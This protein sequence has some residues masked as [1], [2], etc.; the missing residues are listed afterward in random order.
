V[1]HNAIIPKAKDCFTFSY[2]S[3]T[4]GPPKC[5]MISHLNMISVFTAIS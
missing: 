3:G 2:T 5:A 1:N 4:T